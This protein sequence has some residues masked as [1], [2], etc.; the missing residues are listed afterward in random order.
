MRKILRLKPGGGGPVI[1]WLR[2]DGGHELNAAPAI[3]GITARDN[4]THPLDDTLTLPPELDPG[5]VNSAGTETAPG[6][7]SFPDGF[8]Y[9]GL[10][11]NGTWSRVIV[12]VRK[13]A[14]LAGWRY[15]AASAL[16]APASDESEIYSVWIVE[17]A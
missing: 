9:A 16:L 14:V 10:W 3:S 1:R 12:A 6:S 4:E 5:D 8:G 7:G 2:I 15:L 11:T 17:N 13:G